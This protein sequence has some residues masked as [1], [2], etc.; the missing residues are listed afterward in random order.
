[1]SAITL[2]DAERMEL[3]RRA[4]NRAGTRRAARHSSAEFVAFLTNL[5]VNQ[6]PKT[7]KWIYFDPNHRIAAS[8][9]GVTV[10]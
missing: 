9:S 5:V 10:H 1:M 4:N 2:S 7:V 6:A 8:T 3:T